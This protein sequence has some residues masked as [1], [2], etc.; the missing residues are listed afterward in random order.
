[1]TNVL[2]MIPNWST[3]TVCRCGQD[4]DICSRSHC[5]RCGTKF[6]PHRPTGMRRH[7]AE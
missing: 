3:A 7:D 2:K 1:M 6:H 5:P 4:L